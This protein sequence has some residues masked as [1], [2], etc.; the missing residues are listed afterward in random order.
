M[1]PG[2]ASRT[3]EFV[4]MGR[5]IA[6]G[7]TSVPRFSDPTALVLLPDRGRARVERMRAMNSNSVGVRARFRREFMHRQAT[8]M[9]VRT[10][11][12]DDAIRGVQAPQVVILGA[13]LDGR[14]WR[15]P[16]LRG[17][18]VFE[19]DHPDTQRDKRARV[20]VLTQA[21]KE[22]R[23]V[24]VDFVRDDLSDALDRA[25][26]DPARKTIW[27]W[28]GVVMYLTPAD[29]EATLSV[30]ERRSAPGSRVVILYHSPAL[31]L[32]LVGLVVRRM[33]EP[34]RSS[35]KPAA[36]RALLAKHGFDVARDRDL[37][38]IGAEMSE[39]IARAAKPGAHMR[40]VTADRVS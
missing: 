14:A 8:L 5:A 40:V 10:V 33:G 12:I 7:A 1:K 21:A 36:M 38:A 3:S 9:A 25:G 13:G 4:C 26:H 37:R 22:V 18:T 11:A 29:V 28:E 32:L 35:F 34:L 20:G 2:R 27:V 30:I 39:E 16:E 24:A 17:A 23:F 15:M 6:D 31:K 19:V